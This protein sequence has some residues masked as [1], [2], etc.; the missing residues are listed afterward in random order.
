MAWN[1]GSK[2]NSYVR[3]QCIPKGFEG[4]EFIEGDPHTYTYTYTQWGG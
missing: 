2:P 1:C 4:T 3:P